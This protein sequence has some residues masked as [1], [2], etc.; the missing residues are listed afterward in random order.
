MYCTI[1][2]KE[3]KDDSLFCENCGTKVRSSNE[4]IS[5]KK[6]KHEN[7]SEIDANIRHKLEQLPAKET[8]SAQTMSLHSIDAGEDK[9]GSK[10]RK[11]NKA[12][13]IGVAIALA[14]IVIAIVVFFIVG[15]M[16]DSTNKPDAI[17]NKIDESAQAVEGSSEQE[18]VD[19]K[20]ASSDNIASVINFANASST[21]EL[22]TSDIN[23]SSYTVA[24]LIDGNTSSCWCEGVVGNGIGESV[25][26]SSSADQ[27]V[28]G[29]VIWNGY[30]KSEYLY[31]ANTR[32]KTIAVYADGNHVGDFDLKDS[33][34]GSQDIVFEEPVIAKS[35][36]LEISDVYPGSKHEDCCVSEIDFY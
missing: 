34:L 32:P 4:G 25:S 1:C 3:L 27:T 15:V 35:L 13:F 30:Q 10:T 17:I 9:K 5:T 16:G 19:R 31:G 28:K 24:N 29:L 7:A 12:F 11:K 21:S 14:A 8:A 36:T 23:A 22:P 18:E 2:G 6:G 26:F 33:G 20:D